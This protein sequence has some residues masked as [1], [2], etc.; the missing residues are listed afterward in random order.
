MG[1]QIPTNRQQ[2]VEQRGFNGTQNIDAPAAAF[3]GQNAQALVNLGKEGQRGADMM[4]ERAMVIATTRNK[5][6]AEEARAALIRAQTDFLHNPEKGIYRRRG[7]NA[8]DVTRETVKWYDEQSK[9]IANGLEN[10]EQRQLFNQTL[11]DTRM[12]T[13]E[14]VSKFERDE[15]YNYGRD[16]R[17][18]SIKTYE[19]AAAAN[20]TN[21]QVVDEYL[22]KSKEMQI[23]DGV[24][25]EAADLNVNRKRSTIFL[26]NLQNRIDTGDY[27]QAIMYF[28]GNKEA[29]V[30]D[31]VGVAEKI[32]SNARM[33]VD[34]TAQAEEIIAR[35][36]TLADAIKE[37]RATAE[38]KGTE[39]ADTLI[40]RVNKLDGERKTALDQ[41]RTAATRQSWDAIDAGKGPEVIPVWAD[42]STRE[43]MLR[44]ISD[45]AQGKE[46]VTDYTTMANLKKSYQETPGKF[47]TQD[48]T[49]D[50]NKLSA[51]DR[52]QVL[53]WQ[54]EA[55]AGISDE[56]MKENKKALLA[57]EEVRDE[58]R[59]AMRLAYGQEFMNRKSS[60][61]QIALF[62]EKLDYA[63]SLEKER[64]KKDG[65]SR[66]E[67]REI[68]NSLLLKGKVS[69]FGYDTPT[70]AFQVPDDQRDK[71]YVPHSKI[72]EAERLKVRQAIK[73]NN[74]QMKDAGQFD[75]MIPD[76]KEGVERV[77]NAKR[78]NRDMFKPG[79]T[80]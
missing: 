66:K 20:S 37:A 10:D 2:G 53:T 62:Q 60:K 47:A 35:S 71:F 78:F 27:A 58:G 7:A 61:D 21:V 34:T 57:T 73:Q 22:N 51:T 5:A 15:L 38:T 1:V 64:L 23:E 12:S 14:Q 25:P 63:V 54:A 56:Q 6:R 31:D 43:S 55:A 13:E 29:F 19:D 36:P 16:A 44:A 3:G 26:T 28:E 59:E 24:P 4:H 50:L 80:E 52:K 40:T 48:I 65:L 39:Y 8:M 67:V 46:V 45:R 18:A 79:V 72:P 41:E 30:G 11:V 69:R 17:T 75:R 74:R 32:V 70:A 33:T 77:Y 68:A 42:R 9:V 49:K 76:T